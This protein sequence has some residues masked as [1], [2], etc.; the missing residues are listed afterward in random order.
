MFKVHF[1]M[2]IIILVKVKGEK[3]N[4]EKEKKKG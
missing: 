4:S 3:F 2:N 1:F